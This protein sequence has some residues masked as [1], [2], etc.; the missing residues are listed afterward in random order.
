MTP[1]SDKPFGLK[2][3]AYDHLEEVGLIELSGYLDAQTVIDF[4]EQTMGPKRPGYRF[5][6]I[7]LRNLEYISSAG[8]ASLVKIRQE[9]QNRDGDVIFLRPEEKV[10]KALDLVGLSEIFRFAQT[11][12]EAYDMLVQSYPES[13]PP[14]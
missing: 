12:P 10:Y 2:I 8:I 5:Y 13:L 4:N 3:Q 9:N 7:D 1:Q 14:A 11:P 6:I